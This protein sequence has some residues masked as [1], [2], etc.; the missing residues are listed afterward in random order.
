MLNYRIELQIVKQIESVKTFSEWI[1]KENKVVHHLF[2]NIEQM[3]LYVGPIGGK[4]W[5]WDSAEQAPLK[6]M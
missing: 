3:N 5:T 6:L 4:L 1:G 2:A